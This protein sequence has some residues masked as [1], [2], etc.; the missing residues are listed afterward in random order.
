MAGKLPTRKVGETE[1]TA[2]GYGAMGI[3]SFYG[4]APPDEERFKVL[5]RFHKSSNR[6][7]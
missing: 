3:S 1:V 6:V 5:S 2:L 4:S 7:V